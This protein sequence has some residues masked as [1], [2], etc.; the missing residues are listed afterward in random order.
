[1][2][3]NRFYHECDPCDRF[4]GLWHEAKNNLNC[5]V[6]FVCIDS[7][8]VYG[9]SFVLNRASA[10][11][12]SVIEISD[13]S[14]LMCDYNAEVVQAVLE[15]I[16]RRT[17]T[18]KINIVREVEKLFRDWGLRYK[19]YDEGKSNILKYICKRRLSSAANNLHNV[20]LLMLW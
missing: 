6:V 12:K 5:D 20:N 17:T 4:E 15:F 3:I 19:F 7:K 13:K 9:H 14:V 10:D 11:L 2:S 16:Y 18:V 8:S 1:M